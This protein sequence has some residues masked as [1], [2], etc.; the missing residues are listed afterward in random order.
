M[1]NRND[2]P[3]LDPTDWQAFRALAHRMVDEMI[4]GVQGLRQ[5]PVWREMSEAAKDVIRHESLPREPQGE[6]KAYEDFLEH[7]KPYRLGN[8]HP[9]FHGWVMG[10]GLPLASMADMLASDVDPNC[11]GGN[12]GSYF[13]EMQVVDW[14]KEAMG[15]DANASGILSSGGSM[16]NLTALNVARHAKAG[17]DVRANGLH[18]APKL[19]FY[20]STETHSWVQKAAELMGLGSESFRM[21]PVDASYRVDVEDVRRR[22]AEDRAN[23]FQPFCVIANVGTV[24]TGAIDDINALADLCHAE[25]LWLHADGAF[26]ALAAVSPALR[27]LV[28]GLERVDSVVFDLH[29]WMYLPFEIACTLVKDPVAH[30]AAFAKGAAYLATS[31]RGF[32]T[33]G[34]QISERGFELSRGFKALK[35]WMCIKAYGMDCFA[36]AIEMNVEEARHLTRLVEADPSL[37]LVAPTML[38][39]VCFRYRSDSI[40]G[41]RLN[42]LNEELLLRLQERGLAMPSG[43][44]ISGKYVI[45]VA[46]VNHRTRFED[47]DALVADVLG[48]GE[49]LAMEWRD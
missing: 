30:R 33:E 32:V 22:I 31:H 28:D 36:D 29:K 10:P 14:M 42:A 17:F 12:Q 6:V 4:D 7:V 46:I 16:G 49:E 18:N 2:L 21:S 38:N 43:T 24:N 8:P 47:M 19:T 13:V 5:G 23:G 9:R 25:G 37:E 1:L 11:A 15:Y 40:S 26:G 35:A 48:I 41:D 20:G 27:P 34:L 3:T 44:T 45:R 39:I